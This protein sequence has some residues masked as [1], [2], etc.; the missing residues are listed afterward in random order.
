MPTPENN[1]VRYGL[2]NVHYAVLTEAANGTITYGTPKRIPGAISVSLAATTARKIL[3][4]DDS[5]YWTA[6]SLAN[7]TGDMNFALIPDDFRAD[8]LG[9]LTDS[10]SGVKYETNV[11]TTAR[12]ALLFEFDGDAH[13]VRHVLYN[14]TASKPQI[15]GQTVNPDDG[16]DPS[17]GTETITVTAAAR[18]DTLVRAR[19]KPGDSITTGT[20]SEAVTTNIY[21]TWFTNVFVPTLAAA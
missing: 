20:G 4:A 10:A 15:A 7:Y 5:Y 3:A 16:P 8:C 12:F 6:E 11:P 9:E 2:K 19:C 1:K 17:Q 21:D 13:K 18:S 14:C